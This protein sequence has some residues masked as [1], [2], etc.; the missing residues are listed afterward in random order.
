M[1]SSLIIL[2]FLTISSVTFNHSNVNN[3]FQTQ[4]VESEI[5]RDV[6]LEDYYYRTEPYTKLN[7]NFPQ[8]SWNYLSERRIDDASND[9][10]VNVLAD[11]RYNSTE[12]IDAAHNAGIYNSYGGCGPLAMIAI[13]DYFSKCLDYYEIINNP[14]NSIER[15]SLATSV[16]QTVHTY[17]MGNGSYGTTLSD[18]VSGFTTLMSD[19]GLS[20]TLSCQQHPACQWPFI[21]NNI[22]NGFPVTLAT[23]DTSGSTPISYH[24]S[25]IVG[26]ETWKGVNN[27]TGEQCEKTFIKVYANRGDYPGLLYVDIEAFNTSMLACI[28]Y[29]INMDNYYHLESQNFSNFVNNN[30]QGQYFYYEKSQYVQASEPNGLYIH[31]ARLRTSYI[32]N[33]YL[34]MSPKR[35]DAGNSY[36][37]IVKPAHL[38]FF[39]AALWSNSEDIENETFQLYYIDRNGYERPH[40]TLDLSEFSTNRDQPKLYRILLPRGIWD[41]AFKATHQNPTGLRNKGRIVIHDIYSYY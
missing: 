14:Y 24:Y 27:I 8:Y 15:I 34:V 9:G 19:F 29:S 13:L 12:I 4:S 6:T 33:Q 40:I 36:L 39:S 21:K 22:D 10:L 28:T 37:W 16:L 2:N 17:N 11:N 18:Y 23:F 25:N 41:F 7:E 31:T 5:V 20:N 3:Y 26:Y 35:I 38:L 32:E 30:G 1:I